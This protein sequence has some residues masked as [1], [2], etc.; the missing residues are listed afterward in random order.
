MLIQ[1][2]EQHDLL[3]QYSKIDKYL[4]KKEQGKAEKAKNDAFLA[5]KRQ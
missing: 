2:E 1:D 5:Q 3:E 4:L